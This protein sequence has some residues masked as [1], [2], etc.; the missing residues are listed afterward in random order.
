M[1]LQFLVL[2]AGQ[3]LQKL[4]YVCKQMKFI[5]FF[6]AATLFFFYVFSQSIFRPDYIEGD[7]ISGFIFKNYPQF[8]ERK[9]SPVF[10]GLH[11]GVK[12]RGEKF[13][14]RYYRH[15]EFGALVVY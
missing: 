10:G 14:H 8:P 6:V 4:F 7:F 3:S 1:D 2:K 12:W 15:P 13:W 11:V 5:F 9:N